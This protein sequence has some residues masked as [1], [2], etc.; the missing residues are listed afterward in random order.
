MKN[1]F[2][3]FVLLSL[4]HCNKTTS[5]EN[6]QLKNVLND[7]Q[8]ND[9][10]PYVDKDFDFN[11][12]KLKENIHKAIYEGDTIAYNKACKQY[13][14]NGR[15]K[16]FLYYAILMAEKNNF[17]DAYWDISNILSIEEDSP[18]FDKYKSKYGNY[19]ILK[20]YELGQ[21][22]AKESVKYIY[23]EK[24]KKIPKSPSVYCE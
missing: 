1:L 24:G 13:S 9:Y 7:N 10:I 5:K 11:D 22:G 23:L 4:F 14:N 3:L 8:P 20:A 18:L 17:S 19:S 15:Y 12:K 16:E 21:R 6:V 2:M